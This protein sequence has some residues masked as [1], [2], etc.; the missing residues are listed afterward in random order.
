MT[1][2]G[3]FGVGKTSLMKLLCRL[4]FPDTSWV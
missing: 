4:F 2:V 3:P 1:I